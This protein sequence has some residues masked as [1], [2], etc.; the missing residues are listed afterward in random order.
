M[1][2]TYLVAAVPLPV[3]PL[4]CPPALPE[5]RDSRHRRR[6]RRAHAVEHGGRVLAASRRARAGG[7]ALH[8]HRFAACKGCGV[9]EQSDAGGCEGSCVFA[10]G[11]CGQARA[12]SAL[13]VHGLAARRQCFCN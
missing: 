4:P 5:R 9:C 11:Q 10:C 7:S 6:S 3:P 2:P 13:H 8:V 1:I 12:F